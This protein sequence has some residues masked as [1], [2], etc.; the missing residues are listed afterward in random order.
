MKSKSKTKTKYVCQ[1]CG[2]FAPSWLGRC[3][4]CGEWDS[5]VEEIIETKPQSAAK[6]KINTLKEL[7]PI[8]IKDIELDRSIRISSD[9]S[10]LDLV[11]GSGIVKGSLVL[12]GGDPGIGKSTLLLQMAINLSQREK[13]LY[14]SG[15]ESLSQIKLRAQRV[16]EVEKKDLS[17]VYLLADNEI[18]N[19]FRIIESFEPHYLIIDSI[20]TMYDDQIESA[21]GSV[22]QVREITHQLMLISK[23]MGIT[24]FII[25]HVTKSGNIAGPKVLEHMVDTVLYFEGEQSNIH[26]ILRSVKNRFGSTNEIGIFQMSNS[27]LIGVANPSGLFIESKPKDTAGSVISVSM[28]GSRPILVEVQALTSFTAYPSPRRL[29]VGVDYNRINLIVA[30]LEKIG[31]IDLSNIDVYVNLVG[32]IS[33]SET[34]IDLPIAAAIY[35]IHRDKI[36]D[37]DTIIFGE[38][39]LTGEIRGVSN[40]Q[41][42]I[43]EAIKL[44]FKNIIIPE[45]NLSDAP[46]NKANIIPVKNLRDLFKL[47]K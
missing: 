32:G 44:G 8:A 29:S 34:A 15:E 24:T 46:K 12:I 36:I 4:E 10:E 14:V 6:G 22:S 19:I 17:N 2:A 40:S 5:Y 3:P 16:N 33:I 23:H 20:Q 26:R 11:L 35:S 28:E 7:E 43:N 18:K 42:R 47:F 25:G 45:Y 38:L 41:R 27:G 13:V 30:I 39:G 31:R 1:S 9:I 21:P 37:D